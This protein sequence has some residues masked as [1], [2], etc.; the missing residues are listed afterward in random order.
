MII[1]TES[2]SHEF[3]SDTCM[4]RCLSAKKKAGKAMNDQAIAICSSECGRKKTKTSSPLEDGHYDFSMMGH[5]KD[6][7]FTYELQIKNKDKLITFPFKSSVTNT[8]SFH[9]LKSVR[10]QPCKCEELGD[11]PGISR[12]FGQFSEPKERS[13]DWFLFEG[14]TK[15]TKEVY[16]PILQGKVE[17]KH[18]E[19][20]TEFNFDSEKLSGRW[21]LRKLPNIFD[22]DFISGLD[23]QLFWKPELE[24]N[25]IKLDNLNTLNSS[26]FE[27][28][29][30]KTIHSQFQSGVSIASNSKDFV[31]TIAA[32][33]TWIDKFGVKFTY[34][35]DFISTLFNSMNRQ[36]LEGT[37]PLG[38]DKEHDMQDNGKITN[39]ELLDEPI[40]HIRGRGFF[41]GEI[42]DVNGASIDAELEAAFV[43]KFQSWFPISGITKR[44]SLVASPACKVCIF[45]PEA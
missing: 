9:T 39:L 5:W 40:A 11:E 15:D 7:D 29:E 14:V 1:K 17:I 12:L 36:L 10:L 18:T 32:E 33:G 8:E 25:P 2:G 21:L 19:S 43:P 13:A 41:N 23:M 6:K 37:I 31:V 34:T 4:A 30:H 27:N 28:F 44:V 42:G 16:M 22:N 38:V 45:T 3:A 35:R 26:M 24:D 20:T